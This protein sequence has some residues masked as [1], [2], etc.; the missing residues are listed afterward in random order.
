MIRRPTEQQHPTT[1]NRNATVVPI[2]SSSQTLKP[3]EC[4]LP[5]PLL[6][7]FLLLPLTY[8]VQISCPPPSPGIPA[9]FVPFLLLPLT[10]SVQTSCTYQHSWSA[11]H[12]IP[13]FI[14][15]FQC[16]KL[17]LDFA[18]CVPQGSS[19][20]R[21]RRAQMEGLLA[22]EGMARNHGW[23]IPQ[24]QTHIRQ[25][26]LLLRGAP[27]VS[28]FRD[29]VHGNSRCLLQIHFI[30]GCPPSA[31]ICSPSAAPLVAG[32]TRGGRSVLSL[33][34]PVRRYDHFHRLYRVVLQIWQAQTA[35][36]N[37]ACTCCSW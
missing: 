4:C 12:S 29:S 32:A 21:R 35:T 1:P 15:P 13:F 7:P 31:G 17:S 20:F 11:L 14:C 19:R 10:K 26:C 23:N 22:A 36:G 37:T 30:C 5:F 25:V 3:R 28:S 9:F 18:R 24:L 2:R 16:C 27:Q 8:A 33:C 6:A 34:S